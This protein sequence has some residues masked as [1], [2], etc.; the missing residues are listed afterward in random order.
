VAVEDLRGT[1]GGILTINF[2][3]PLLELCLEITPL[4]EEEVL[5]FAFSDSPITPPLLLLQDLNF[6]LYGFSGFTR[7]SKLLTFSNEVKDSAFPW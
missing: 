1:I 4:V 6:L 2:S 5:H 7:S 3:L